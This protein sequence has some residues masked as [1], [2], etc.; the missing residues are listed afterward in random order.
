MC[1]TMP[2]MHRAWRG[3]VAAAALGAS[4]VGLLVA[5]NP[6]PGAGQVTVTGAVEAEDVTGTV[7]CQKPGDGGE[8]YIPSWEWAGTIDGQPASLVVSSQTAYEP[9]EGAFRVGSSTWYHFLPGAP[10]DITAERIDSD[11]TLHMTAALPR[12]GGGDP[13]E[14]AATLRCP[15]WGHSVVTGDVAG[16]LDG[17]S[18]CP[19]PGEGGSDAYVT[20]R[21]HSSNLSGQIAFSELSFAGLAGPEIDT[22]VLRHYGVIWGAANQAGQPD[23]IEATVDDAGV[24]TATATFRRLDGQPGTVDVDAVVRCP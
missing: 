24:L 23:Q 12:H 17:V 11:G 22:A 18:S 3:R 10:G 1:D 2:A 7:T 13:V 16:T 21:V 19:A 15:G 6:A 4:L 8:T 14:I 5:C 20:Y 9:S